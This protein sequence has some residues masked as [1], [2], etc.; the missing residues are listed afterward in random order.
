MQPSL[1]RLGH[2]VTDLSD[3]PSGNMNKELCI[4]TKNGALMDRGCG[5]NYRYLCEMQPESHEPGKMSL[6]QC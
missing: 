2:V 5:T 1:L 6:K 4:R 3:E